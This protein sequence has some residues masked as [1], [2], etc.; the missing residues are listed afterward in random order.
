MPT[1]TYKPIATTTLTSTSSSVTFSSLGSYT[2]IIVVASVACS[3]NDNTVTFRLNGDASANYSNIQIRGNGSA[4]TSQR[5]NDNGSIFVARDVCPTTT[6]G[7]HSLICNVMNYGNSSMYKT[8]MARSNTPLSQTYNGT[9]ATVG[10]W[11]NTAAVTSITLGVSGSFA[12]GSTFSLYG[13]L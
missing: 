13:I 3:T 12:I 10:V 6:L 8:I 11:R 2:D 5:S 4:A 1:K 7:Q 9:E